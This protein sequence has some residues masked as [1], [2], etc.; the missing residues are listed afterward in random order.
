MGTPALFDLGCIEMKDDS[1][2]YDP[3]QEK[4]LIEKAAEIGF[5]KAKAFLELESQIGEAK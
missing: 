2:L 1:P 5:P 4:K 3:D